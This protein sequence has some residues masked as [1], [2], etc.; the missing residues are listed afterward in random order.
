[1]DFLTDKFANAI[2]IQVAWPT[3]RQSNADSVFVKDPAS[4]WPDHSFQ[5]G[6]KLM[7]A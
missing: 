2:F 1:M 4:F 6:R 3:A 5:F 7:K